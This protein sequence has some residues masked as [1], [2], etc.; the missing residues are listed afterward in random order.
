MRVVLLLEELV[1][2]VRQAHL[3]QVPQEVLHTQEDLLLR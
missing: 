3:V 1:P 2:E